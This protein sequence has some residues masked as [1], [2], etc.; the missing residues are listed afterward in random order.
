MAWTTPRDW[1]T[2]ELVTAAIM[3]AHVRD[4]LSA[5][6]TIASKQIVQL[7]PF[8]FKDSEGL[9]TG[10]GKA[11]LTIPSKINGWYLYAVH[12]EVKTAPTTGGA[13]AVEIQIHN[14]TDTADILSTVLTVDQDETGS[15][16]ATAAVINTSNNQVATNDVLRLDFDAVEDAIGCIV[17]LT[18][19][20]DQ[21]S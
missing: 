5:L 6:Y 16:T 18:F 3:N 4:N 12:A 9:S 13:G 21:I 1:T 2:S 20:K 7:E 17:T 10:D 19:S 11:Y 8:S 15:D 14:V